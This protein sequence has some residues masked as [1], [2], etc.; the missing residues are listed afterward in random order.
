MNQYMKEVLLGA[1]MVLCP[2]L[3]AQQTITVENN[4][5]RQRSELIAI[6]AEQLG[7]KPQTSVVVRDAFGIEQ[8]TSGR[9]M[10]NC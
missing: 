6:S 2:A 3:M 4:T 9:T 5:G 1:F 8:Q 7:M 10:V